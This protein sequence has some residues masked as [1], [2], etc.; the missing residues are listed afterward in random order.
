MESSPLAVH[1]GYSLL[2]MFVSPAHLPFGSRRRP[3][4][5]D[6]SCGW[7]CTNVVSRQTICSVEGGQV[8]APVSCVSRPQSH[9]HISLSTVVSLLMFGV[10]SELGL[11]RISPS[12]VATSQAQRS[13]GC[14]CERRRPRTCA[15]ILMVL[16]SWYTGASGRRG[17]PE[18]SITHNTLL[19]RCLS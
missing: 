18:C 17:T 8:L 13:G 16:L 11:P 12:H 9:A 3:L 2:P 5:V 15:E 14:R 6:S 19:R 1:M 7:W 4:A 10:G